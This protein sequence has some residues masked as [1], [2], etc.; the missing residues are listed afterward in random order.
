MFDWVNRPDSLAGK[1]QTTA[2]I[3]WENHQGWLSRLLANNA[4]RLWIIEIGGRPVG[5]V[6]LAPDAAGRRMVDIFI[7]PEARRGGLARA[8]LLHALAEAGRLWPAQPVYAEVLTDNLPSHG[9]FRR[10]GFALEQTAAGHSLYVHQ[11]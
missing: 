11:A 10:L 4:A 5:Q 7:L 3:H 9:L 8:A 1:R 6:R 2:P